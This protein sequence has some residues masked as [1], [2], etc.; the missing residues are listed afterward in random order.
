M[1]G[2]SRAST[3]LLSAACALAAPDVLPPGYRPVAHE[4][5][6]EASPHF[7]E[8]D[9][10][11]APTA[12]FGGCTRVVPGEPFRFSSKYGTRLYAL[13][14]GATCPE[15]YRPSAGT[16]AAAEVALASGDIPVQ[17]TGSVRAI[18]PV[19]HV[20]TTL[21]IASVADGAIRLEVVDERTD[22]DP[23]VAWAVGL[24][25]AFGAGGIL[26]LVRRGR[27]RASVTA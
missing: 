20:R 5:V 8:H 15:G 23:A 24:A 7:A 12:G 14:K 1:T 9:F 16:A 19:E 21:R 10:F 2:A 3:V 17:E 26:V 4:L 22:W 18:S 13:A 11:A 25:F 6:L 27:A